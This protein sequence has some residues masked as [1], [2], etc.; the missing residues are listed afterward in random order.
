MDPLNWTII[1]IL[2]EQRLR[3]QRGEFQRLHLKASE[4]PARRPS[5]RSALASTFV[6]WGLRL[7]PAAGERLRAPRASASAQKARHQA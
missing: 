7:D 2:T 1:A 5:L 6:R 3:E 4:S